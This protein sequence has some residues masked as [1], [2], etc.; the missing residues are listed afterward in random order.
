VVAIGGR[1]REIPVF[2]GYENLV[3]IFANVGCCNLIAGYEIA[4]KDCEVDGLI[5]EDSV[6][7]FDCLKVGSWAP[8]ILSW[9]RSGLL[10]I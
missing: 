4:I 7:N 1:P 5:V 8:D 2:Q 6:D 3:N 9:T 10:L